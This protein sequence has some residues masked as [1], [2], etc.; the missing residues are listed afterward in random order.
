MSYDTRLVREIEARFGKA[1]A[2]VV[3]EQFNDKGITDTAIYLG[4]AKSTLLWWMAK[5][6]LTVETVVLSP[7]DTWEIIPPQG[8]NSG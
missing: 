5:S 2:L 8:K 6:S 3:Q 1:I 7:G 4:I